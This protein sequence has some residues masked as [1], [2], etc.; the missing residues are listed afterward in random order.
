MTDTLAVEGRRY[1]RPSIESDTGFHSL[2]D[3]KTTI[4]I[5]SLLV[6]IE[7]ISKFTEFDLN[8][9]SV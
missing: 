3:T 5:S 4:D 2:Q 9:W 7:Y 6:V 8:Y 1:G